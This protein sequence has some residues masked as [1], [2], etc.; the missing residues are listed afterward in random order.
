MSFINLEQLPFVGMSDEFHGEKHG[1][2]FSAHIV[3]RL[4]SCS[5]LA[6]AG[7]AFCCYRV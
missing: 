3:N 1:A 5:A 7:S 4:P 2:P 6:K